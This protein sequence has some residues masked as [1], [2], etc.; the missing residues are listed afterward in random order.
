MAGLYIESKPGE[1]GDK[2]GSQAE[3][4]CS[5]STRRVPSMGYGFR[6]DILRWQER[7]RQRSTTGRSGLV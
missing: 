7:G 4:E 1:C 3:F 6:S 2:P 5:R